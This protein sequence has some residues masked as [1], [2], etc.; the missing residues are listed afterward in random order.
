[1]MRDMRCRPTRAKS[2]LLKSSW[3][4]VIEWVYNKEHGFDSANTLLYPSNRR[5]WL[6][7]YDPLL[8]GVFLPSAFVHQWYVKKKTQY[9]TRALGL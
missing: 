7:W 8:R 5:T 4:V 9:L 1:M 6:R 2:E 3:A